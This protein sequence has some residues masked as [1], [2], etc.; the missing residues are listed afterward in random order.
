MKT[1][2]LLASAS[3]LS[4]LS[5][6]GPQAIDT[7][8]GNEHRASVILISGDNQENYFTDFFPS[9]E[10]FSKVE[11][12]TGVTLGEV[13]DSTFFLTTSVPLST[14][15]LWQGNQPLTLVVEDGRNFREGY[16][17]LY[18]SWYDEP[19]GKVGIAFTQK[20]ATVVALWQNTQLPADQ[21][22]VNDSNIIVT[23][24]KLAKDAPERSYLRVYAATADQPM[25][26]ILLPLT[27]D[28]HVITSAS[29]LNRHDPETQI[30]Y[31][32]MIDRFNNGKAENDWTYAQACAAAGRPCDVLPQADYQGGDVV[33][34]TQKIREGFFTDL[35]VNTI[36]VSPITQNPYDAWGLNEKPRT[37]FSGYHGYW[38]IYITKVEER[39]ATDEELRELLQTAHDHDINVV[40]D[41][42]AN[43]LHINSPLFQAHPDWATDSLTR[44]GT[45]NIE[46]WDGEYRLTTWFDKHI[47]SLQLDRPDVA[48]QLTD[49]ALYWVRNFEF[50]GF[51]H[52]A[53]KHIPLNYWRLFGRKLATDPQLNQR[54]IWMIGETYGSTELI[55][56]YVK[57]GMLNAQFDFNIY[58]TAIDV[59]ANHW[60][61]PM[62]DLAN[63]IDESGAAYGSHHTMGNISGNHDK[64]R[65]VS[66]AGGDLSWDED[67]K[68]AGWNRHV[69]VGDSVRGY[70]KQL[71]LNK[72]NLTIPG[73]PCIYQG[74]EYGQE[75]ANDPDN[76]RF[77]RFDGYNRFEQHNL[78]E[79][80]RFAAERRARIELQFGD[81]LP[82]Y[83]DDQVL[84]FLRTY[85]GDGVLVGINNGDVP[86]Q[87]VVNIPAGLY[88]EGAKNDVPVCIPASD[89]T[90]CPLNTKQ[91]Q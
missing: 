76:R 25:S 64:S 85:L 47:P 3:V 39:F 16:Q 36:W 30:L 54:H 56:S 83:V 89:V 43:H 10:T 84:I 41:Y 80:R 38:P 34:I 7:I 61:K 40:L 19:A 12:G 33:G 53:C 23:L 1:I 49:S 65:F 82:L 24:P 77:M 90:F 35:G 42:V 75:G 73:V 15:T 81:Y 60:N 87:G 68:A 5:A 21:V 78:D 46:Q 58:H 51:R 29:Q 8:P 9:I 14:V 28:G 88:P 67:G 70:A 63:V 22:V 59:F 66:L 86:F 17:R 52:D 45:P 31:S 11:A 4:V 26:D 79:V 18:S 6:C 32:L 20:P 27:Q 74:D 55:N 71:L 69:G 13:T 57:S 72:L 37:R 62:R 44:E 91:Y 2:K 50:D 48:D